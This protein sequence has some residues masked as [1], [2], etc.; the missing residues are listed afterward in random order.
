MTMTYP[1][2]D[3]LTMLR[4]N[5]RHMQRYPSLTLMLLGQPILFLLLFVYLFGGTLGNGLGG[6]AADGASGREA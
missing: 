6:A 1:M 2:R 4:R 5:L 3:S